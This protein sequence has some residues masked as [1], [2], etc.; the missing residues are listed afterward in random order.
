MFLMNS[1]QATSCYG[2]DVTRPSCL[3]SS[4]KAWN[5]KE[6]CL[7]NLNPGHI[8]CPYAIRTRP[9]F[10]IG[11]SSGPVSFK[12]I[13]YYVSLI[14]IAQGRATVQDNLRSMQSKKRVMSSA[15]K[16]CFDDCLR[17]FSR[18][19]V[20]RSSHSCSN[21]RSSGVLAAEVNCSTVLVDDNRSFSA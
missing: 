21:L 20:N 16:G 17:L 1:R 3:Q 14:A 8:K 4:I 19:A 9:A 5:R 6:A 2:T 10:Q 13:K 7:L 18:N 11:P 15:V 12:S